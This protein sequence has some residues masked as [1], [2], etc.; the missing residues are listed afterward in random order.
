MPM[1]RRTL[2]TGTTMESKPSSKAGRPLWTD[3][4]HWSDINAGGNGFEMN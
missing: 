3:Q 1:R 2:A 4:T